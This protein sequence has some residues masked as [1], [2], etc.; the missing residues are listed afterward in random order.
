MTQAYVKTSPDRWVLTTD[1][2]EILDA[3]PESLVFVDGL[4]PSEAVQAVQDKNPPSQDGLCNLYIPQSWGPHQPIAVV[5][6]HQNPDVLVHGED[7]YCGSDPAEA[8]EL[9][10]NSTT[11]RIKSHTWCFYENENT[12]Q[13]GCYGDDRWIIYDPDKVAKLQAQQ[14]RRKHKQQ[15]QDRRNFPLELIETIYPVLA[16]CQSEMVD[17]GIEG[18]SL[19]NGRGNRGNLLALAQHVRLFNALAGENAHRNPGKGW[20]TSNVWKDF[21]QAWK[22]HRKQA[23]DWFN[24]NNQYDA[25]LIGWLDREAK[26]T[27]FPRKVSKIKLK[28]LYRGQK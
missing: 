3:D 12:W 7:V 28:K 13:Y 24:R 5:G 15:Q 22:Q 10:R 23:V 16:R 20:Q 26:I 6:Y 4:T 14:E 25:G 2:R 27:R 21:I 11:G 1:E 17:A 9:A 19:R 18:L 8:T